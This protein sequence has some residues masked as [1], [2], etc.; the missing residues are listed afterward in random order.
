[1]TGIECKPFLTRSVHVRCGQAQLAGDLVIPE[2]AQGLV[3]FAHGSGSSRHSP[4]NQAVAT[5]LQAG[6]LATLLFDLLS[7]QEEAID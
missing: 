2:H 3:L 7:T 1:M 5:T 6:R 4:R